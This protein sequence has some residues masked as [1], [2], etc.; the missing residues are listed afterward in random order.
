MGV[1]PQHDIR[2]ILSKTANRLTL[3]PRSRRTTAVVQFV[4][5]VVKPNLLP[6]ALAPG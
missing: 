5:L 4:Y 1:Q 2:R 3:S 6:S